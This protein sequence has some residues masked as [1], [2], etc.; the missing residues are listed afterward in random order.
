VADWLYVSSIAPRKPVDASRDRQPAPRIVNAA[1]P[2]QELSGA[3]DFN[4]TSVSY[5]RQFVEVSDLN[6][7]LMQP[8]SEKS[9]PIP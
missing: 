4:C 5:G 6:V 3:T 8:L 7:A 9:P 2:L 1:Q